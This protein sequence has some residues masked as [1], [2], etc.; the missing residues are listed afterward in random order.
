[1]KRL[2]VAHEGLEPTHCAILEERLGSGTIDWR[3]IEEMGGDLPGCDVLIVKDLEVTHETVKSIDGLQLVVALSPGKSRLDE[4]ALRAAGLAVERMKWPALIGVAEHTLLLMLA[5]A[6]RFVGS[7]T[8]ARTN[9]YPATVVP[10]ETTQ[11]EYAFNW[12]QETG[13]DVLYRRTLGIVGMGWIGREVAR[14]AAAFGMNVIYH[15]PCRLS[16]IE[17]KTL[18]V[19]PVSF[20]E[21]LGRSDFVSLHTRLSEGTERMIDEDALGRMKPTAYLINT[22][23]GRLIDEEA[24]IRALQ[25][26][27]I[28]GAG[29]D[30]F[31]KEPPEAENPLL[32]MS[33]VLVTPHDAGIFIGDAAVM[34]GHFLAD[35]IETQVNSAEVNE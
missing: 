24:L 22:A 17:E 26:E 3:P 14:R 18:G 21:L 31:W 10:K 6:K 7:V 13:L 35:A 20:D 32:S 5:L 33:N 29:L 8:R 2:V 9:Q 19:S 12:T 34:V 27:Q 11:T 23:R 1:M 15:D 16:E 4:D 30:V 28:A 25:T